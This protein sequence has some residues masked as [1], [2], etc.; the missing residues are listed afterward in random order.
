MKRVIFF[1][2]AAC[3]AL[4]NT[5]CEPYIVSEQKLHSLRYETTDGK[6][7]ELDPKNFNPT[8]ASNKYGNWGEIL[9][10]GDLKSI[11]ES[12]FESQDRLTM[13]DLPVGLLYINGDAFY[14]CNNLE[15]VHIPS[16][17]IHIGKYAFYECNNIKKVYFY[18]SK[19]PVLADFAFSPNTIKSKAIYVPEEHLSAYIK[20]WGKDYSQYLNTF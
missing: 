17:V 7:L 1:V 20:K 14:D 6:T 15:K 10:Y 12:A 2:M 4:L 8:I 16:T 13:V 9:F 18:G 11:G 3:T 19:P 5:G